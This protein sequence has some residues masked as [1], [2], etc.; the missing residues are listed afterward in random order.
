M[1]KITSILL[2]A[3]IALGCVS[4][5]GCGAKKEEPK[6][7]NR[8]KIICT[9]FPQYDWVKNIVGSDSKNVD[10]ELLLDNGIDLHNYQPTVS[11]IAKAATADLFIY[12]GGESD[13]WVDDFLA[14]ADNPDLQTLS[15]MDAIDPVEEEALEGMQEEE[16]KHEEEGEEE[17]EYDEHVWLSLKNAQTICTA[18]T[19]KLSAIDP[20]NA[21]TYKSN[22]AA[23]NARL[24]DL[25]QKFTDMV[26]S[27]KRKELLFADRFPFRYLAD[28]YGL[29]CY[30]AF[31]GCSAETEASFTTV[32]FLSDKLSELDLPV[33]IIIDG[34]MGEL[35]DT[36][37][38]NSTA[39]P[40]I[41]I[42]HSMQSVIK[43]DVESGADYIELM[44]GNY[45]VLSQA[46]N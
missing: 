8:I 15:L 46:L 16:E 2:A 12:V 42:M 1:K 40:T 6:T 35:A 25:D 11:D 21:E 13:K 10:L 34:S 39:H 45:E 19:E 27:A 29:T 44:Q 32:S 20:D 31:S 43:S 17:I 36:I 5:F 33:I 4:F 14:S 18:I 23:Y 9:I 37:I 22:C 28:D 7:D 26:S 24:A 38:E 41:A 3:I 30:A